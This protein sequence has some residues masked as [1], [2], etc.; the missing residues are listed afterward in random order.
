MKIQRIHSYCTLPLS[1]L[2][3]W[4]DNP[5][6]GTAIDE[7]DAIN[8]LIESVGINQMINL[9]KDILEYGLSET[10][11]PSVVQKDDYFL[12]YDGNRRIS[13]LKVLC[14]PSLISD[15]EVRLRFL[16]LSKDRDLSKFRKLL[17][18][19]TTIDRAL[20]LMDRNHN[21]EQGGIGRVAWEAFQRDIAL[22]KRGFAPQYKAAH[23]VC[24]ILFGTPTKKNFS[25][26]PTY[27][28]I[29]RIYGSTII[30][31]YLGVTEDYRNLSDDSIGKVKEMHRILISARTPLEIKVYSR[32]FHNVDP[33]DEKMKKFLIY[34][35]SNINTFEDNLPDTKSL[36]KEPCL[37]G[38]TAAP[39]EH[40]SQEKAI[41][42]NPDNDSPTN[43]PSSLPLAAASSINANKVRPAPRNPTRTTLI[44]DTSWEHRFSSLPQK[45]APIKSLLSH[46]RKVP[47][48]DEKLYDNTL[49][50]ALLLR[51]LIDQST[52]IF[53]EEKNLP[54]NNNLE[55]AINSTIDY[56]V[57]NNFVAREVSKRM[58]TKNI[59]TLQSYVH[60]FGAKI[61]RTELISIFDSLYV[62][63]ETCLNS[64]IKNSQTH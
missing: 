19:N 61:G 35:K 7:T 18:Y 53:R 24:K 38:S 10:D 12:V 51:A 64:A 17:V 25:N 42:N 56:M 39:N 34:Y 54:A 22:E 16:T 1:K 11:I 36:P 27:T 55:G 14:R 8:L 9:S 13:C 58:N 60:H 50:L 43:N 62:Y 52:R 41:N 2:K 3:V 4:T 30:K 31:E 29:D 37:N 23:A 5:R 48:E 44:V 45:Y 15:K 6:I 49:V 57:K 32:F 21:G 46:L 47:F 40:N 28:D 63:I 20:H 26:A 33:D 59:P